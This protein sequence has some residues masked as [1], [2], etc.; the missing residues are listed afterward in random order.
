MTLNYSDSMNIINQQGGT[1]DIVPPVLDEY[2]E[3]PH[4]ARRKNWKHTWRLLGMYF[5]LSSC[6]VKMRYETHERSGKLARNQRDM[7]G[8]MYEK[9]QGGVSHVRQSFRPS[10]DGASPRIAVAQV[11]RTA[12]HEEEPHAVVSRLS[13]RNPLQ[14]VSGHPVARRESEGTGY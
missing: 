13:Q 8:Q 1:V 7:K 10:V 12:S 4:R 14:P 9:Q 3:P 5:T 6:R 11:P 2:R